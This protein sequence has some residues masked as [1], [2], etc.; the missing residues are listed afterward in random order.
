[1][2]SDPGGQRMFMSFIKV[3]MV[4]GDKVCFYHYLRLIIANIKLL[5]KRC[6]LFLNEDE[7]YVIHINQLFISQDFKERHFLMPEC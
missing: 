1:M 2:G 7:K 5:G 6:I 4:T 3:L